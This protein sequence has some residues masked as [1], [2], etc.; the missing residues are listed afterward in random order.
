MENL[1]QGLMIVGVGI[2]G[3]FVNLLVLMF[4][5]LLIGKICNT[6]TEKKPK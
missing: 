6:K 2:G 5:L 4:A 3:V 1:S